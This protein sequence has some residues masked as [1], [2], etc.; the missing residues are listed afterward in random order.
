MYTVTRKE[1]RDILKPDLP[2]S[3]ITNYGGPRVQGGAAHLKSVLIIVHI[4]QFVNTNVE[5][6]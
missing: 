3:V 2:L 6:N 5:K 4:A 1:G